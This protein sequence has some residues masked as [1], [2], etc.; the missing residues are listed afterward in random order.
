MSPIPPK[1]SA[2]SVAS[3]YSWSSEVIW[4]RSRRLRPAKRA[5]V[6]T[7]RR[8]PERS[9]QV[10]QSGIA[11]PPA[12]RPIETVPDSAVR[13]QPNSSIKGLKKTGKL[14]PAPASTPRITKHAPTMYQP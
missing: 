9:V 12:T 14:A 11:S 13:L 1:K 7:T 10:P 4:P 5:A 8:G 2:P 3:Q 6:T